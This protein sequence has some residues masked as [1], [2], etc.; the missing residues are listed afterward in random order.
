VR[1][2]LA[3]VLLALL[4][5]CSG[6]AGTGDKGYVGG[7]GAVRLVPAAERGEPVEL[8]QDD[9][10]GTPVDLSALRGAVVVVNVWWSGCAPCVKEAPLLAEVAAG[11][12]SQSLG[13]EFVGVNIRDT[14]VAA[15]Q[16]FERRF[17]W[18]FPTIFDPSGKALLAFS[19]EAS[20]RT[21]PTT[22]V[23][24]PAGR[25]AA[26]IA[27]PLPSTRTLTGLIDEVAG[28]HDG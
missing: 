15:A 4:T 16:A 21:I 2:A 14:S 1:V 19:S 10:G 28:S 3:A 7:D 5:S 26:V 23:L 13:A 20:P 24:D 22:L 27:G 12:D 8:V 6:V 11:S 9:L 17:E 18:E 25:V